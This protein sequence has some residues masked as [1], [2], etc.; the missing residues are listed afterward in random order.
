MEVNI[1]QVNE[2]YLNHMCDSTIIDWENG[3]SPGRRQ[4]IMWTNA[5]LLLIKPLQ[6]KYSEI[7]IKI[8]SLSFKKMCLKCRLWNGGRLV[9]DP[10][11]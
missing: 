7:L 5:R 4:A 2:N 8:H 6:T 3:L 10:M 1:I 11:C 9:S